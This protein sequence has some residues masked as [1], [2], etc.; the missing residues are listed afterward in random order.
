MKSNSPLIYAAAGLLVLAVAI[1]LFI[2]SGDGADT[3]ERNATAGETGRANSASSGASTADAADARLAKRRERE[4]NLQAE[5]VETYGEA[6]T[7]LARTVAGNVVGLLEDAV[8]MGEMATNGQMANAFGGPRGGLAMALGRLG[9]DLQLSE[10]QSGRASELFQEYQKRQLEQTKSAVDSLKKDPTALMKLMLA[11][12]D[13]SRGKIDEA[14]YRSM[15][16]QAGEELTGVINPLDRENFRGGQPLE[17]ESFVTGMRGILE[18]EQLTSFDAAVAER[19]ANRAE[20]EQS[21]SITNLPHMELEKLDETVVAGKKLTS[22]IKQ[23]MEGFS[24]LQD[25]GPL[26]EQQRRQQQESQQNQ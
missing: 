12:D 21:R 2:R 7:N 19:E 8:E 11:G 13:F 5:L 23:M 10:E 24:G 14:S 18:G 9:R 26:M 6:R 3:A 17:D 25:L 15:Q 22:G 1:A 20:A 16:Q 4:S